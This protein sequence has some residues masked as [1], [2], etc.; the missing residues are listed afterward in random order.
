MLSKPVIKQLDK[1]TSLNID[2]INK[3]IN[4]EVSKPYFKVGAPLNDNL[5][6]FI[7]GWLGGYWHSA[8]KFE[9]NWNLFRMKTLAFLNELMLAHRIKELECDYKYNIDNSELII[10][11]VFDTAIFRKFNHFSDVHYNIGRTFLGLRQ[12][13]E[14][15]VLL[16]N[17]NANLLDIYKYG[18]LP[19]E[20]MYK[21]IALEK[22]ACYKNEEIYKLYKYAISKGK[23]VVFL[24]D[25]YLGT[26]IITE[27]L[28][29]C[30]YENPTVYVSSDIK[31]RKDSGEAYSFLKTMYKNIHIGNM[32]MIGDNEHSDYKKAKKG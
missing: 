13:A 30:G 29:K 14:K 15:G 10:F 17:K 24:S 3:C 25:M 31:S 16:I 9:E 20:M 21:E 6:Y 5:K 27:M 18:N 28:N 22:A 2:F 1:I 12:D 7:E 32:L 8:F 23:K 26:E 19:K 11:D 4:T